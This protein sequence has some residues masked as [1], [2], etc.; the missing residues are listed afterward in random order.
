ML[1]SLATTRW[2]NVMELPPRVEFSWPIALGFTQ[3]IMVE[4]LEKVTLQTHPTYSACCRENPAAT[5]P[6]YTISVLCM[7]NDLY[8]LNSVHR[9]MWPISV[10]LHTLLYIVNSIPQGWVMLCLQGCMPNLKKYGNY[11]R[12]TRKPPQEHK[13]RSRDLFYHS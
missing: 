13:S 3:L 8:Y 1:V 10:P 4:K 7:N 6:K 2:G 5:L 12:I 11:L 9:E